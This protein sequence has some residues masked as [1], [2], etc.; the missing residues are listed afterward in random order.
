MFPFLTWATAISV[1]VWIICHKHSAE[2]RRAQATVEMAYADVSTTWSIH[3]SQK[4]LFTGP[5]FTFN[6][7]WIKYTNT[8][9]SAKERP[10]RIISKTWHLRAGQTN[11]DCSGHPWDAKT[12]KG[13]TILS[14]CKEKKFSVILGI[15]QGVDGSAYDEK[16]SD[17][18]FWRPFNRRDSTALCQ[19][20]WGV[21]EVTPTLL[22]CPGVEFGILFQLC[23]S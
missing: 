10:S 11:W 20:A 19:V 5:S 17:F 23:K 15:G 2:N 22:Q 14:C 7:H 4:Q 18:T 13:E 1:P 21:R 9:E 8:W 16:G 6:S 12:R 3:R